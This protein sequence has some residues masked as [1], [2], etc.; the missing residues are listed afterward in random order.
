MSCCCPVFL[1]DQSLHALQQITDGLDSGECQLKGL[2][3]YL[4]GYLIV[5][6]WL[7][8]PFPKGKGQ[9]QLFDTGDEGGVIYP[10]STEHL[11]YEDQNQLYAA[12]AIG[13]SCPSRGQLSGEGRK[14][15]LGQWKAGPAQPL[16]FNT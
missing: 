14:L 4:G 5:Q 9:S 12:G 10:K 8:G 2:D 15:S 3:V 11:S 6:S 1:Q 13:A 7:L 16:Y